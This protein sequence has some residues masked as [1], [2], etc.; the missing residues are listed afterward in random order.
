MSRNSPFLTSSFFSSSPSPTPTLENKI[1]H[2]TD[3]QIRMLLSA[4]FTQRG[5]VK[6]ESELDENLVKLRDSWQRKD[7]DPFLSNT[8]LVDKIKETMKD[9]HDYFAQHGVPK[10]S[11]KENS[12]FAKYMIASVLK[13][14]VGTGEVEANQSI[15]CAIMYDFCNYSCQVSLRERGQQEVCLESFPPQGE[16]LKCLDGTKK[17]LEDLYNNLTDSEQTRPF[18]RAH[19]VLI[20]NIVNYLKYNVPQGNEV[21]I[22][23]YL[24]Y[25][26]GLKKEKD[27]YPQSQIPTATSWTIHREFSSSFKQVLLEEMVREEQE[28]RG[29]IT[30][31]FQ[32]IVEGFPNVNLKSFSVDEDVVAERLEEDINSKVV[33]E[34][35]A[36]ASACIQAI[37]SGLAAYEINGKNFVKSDAY[38]NSHFDQ[39]LLE[40]A[41]INTPAL[42]FL[43]EFLAQEK[44]VTLA[45]EKPN[46]TAS[47]QALRSADSSIIFSEAAVRHILILLTAS[48]SVNHDET[49]AGLDAL[50]MMGDHLAGNC[51]IAFVGIVRELNKIEPDYLSQKIAPQLEPFLPNQIEKI[52]CI[53]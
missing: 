21:H 37:N 40:Q 4:I 28:R 49:L 38:G 29:K 34:A 9:T 20:R 12:D 19:D 41:T 32:N 14:M 2:L 8:E 10:D 5:E 30:A 50:W 43:N 51:P 22:P 31:T 24:D 7:G 11:L 33:Q 25:S 18:T 45:A 35:V 23:N 46:K 48:G 39:D 6:D 47:L 36:E 27:I 3:L 44:I 52:Q 16:Y 42:E 13:D 53:K 17:R 15:Y 26:L 1:N